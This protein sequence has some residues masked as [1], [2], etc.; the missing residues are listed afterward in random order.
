M[1]GVH[2]LPPAVVFL[3]SASEDSDAVGGGWTGRVTHHVEESPPSQ[4]ALDP[5]KGTVSSL[6][7]AK[8]H[9]T[10]SGVIQG[11]VS[12]YRVS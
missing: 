9:S 3:V 4:R 12:H 2:L 6:G 1:V 11:L 8:W 7:K 10:E 5:G